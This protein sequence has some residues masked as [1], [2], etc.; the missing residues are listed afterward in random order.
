MGV[1]DQIVT[2][3]IVVK[4]DTSDAKAQIKS[5]RGVEKEAAKERLAE[6]EAGNK[7]IEAQIA[8]WVKAGI[9][10]AAVAKGF[11]FAQHAA[12]SYLEDV[13]LQAAAG[14]ASLDRLQK[15]THGLVEAD[16]LL[17]F[18]GKA[19]HGVWKLNQA[20]METVLR[21]AMALRKTMGVELQPTVDS[22]TEAIAKGS[23]RALKEFGIQAED[24]Q[25]VLKALSKSF[26]DL[27]GNTSLTGDSFEAASVKWKDAID[28][29]IGALG[30]LVTALEP[31]IRLAADAASSAAQ[32][33]SSSDWI[34]KAMG[35]GELGSK[36]MQ[37]YRD[38]MDRQNGGGAT[39]AGGY[40]V[41]SPY[42]QSPTVNAMR[43]IYRSAMDGVDRALA[44]TAEEIEKIKNRK[45]E[46]WYRKDV[47]D[48]LDFISRIGGTIG[49]G[50][51]ALGSAIRGV[52]E[53]PAS[54][55]MVGLD[56]STTFKPYMKADEIAAWNDEISKSLAIAEQT[57]QRNLLESIFGPVDQFNV[58]AAGF[59]ILQSA[60]A[61]AFD[62][63]ITGSK[64]LGDAIKSAIAEGLRAMAI[65]ML[66][67]SLKHLAYA[68]GNA[69]FGNFAGA[70]AHLKSA[71][72]FGAGAA[73]AGLAAKHMGAGQAPSAGIPAGTS[74]GGYIGNGGGGSGPQTS[75]TVIYV[76]SDAYRMSQAEREHRIS[77]AARRGQQKR[78]SNVVAH[79]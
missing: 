48:P 13:R 52:A 57:R 53:D 8:T 12:K 14:S 5:L 72:L 1:L 21:G 38:L 26:E 59:G 39:G 68:A 20:E 27:E 6:I 69:A 73:A 54:R 75:N 78:S 17:A 76:T 35:R 74:A 3:V 41:Y 4:A 50:A 44:E 25:G 42:G 60:A 55:G 11:Q 65:Q 15:A 23:T 63:W 16:N 24:K 31:V 29:L 61:A 30:Q 43:R 7:G 22:L 34:L 47:G 64:S 40:P 2:Q 49:A 77:D 46:T 79:E 10:V 58:Y 28:D 45:H 37:A 66:M 51:G 19:Q 9:A 18:A 67:E 32:A 71:A 62:A 70:G 36:N 33:S 56:G